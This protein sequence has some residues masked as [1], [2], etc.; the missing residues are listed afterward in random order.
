MFYS[1]I[2]TDLYNL[3]HINK[4]ECQDFLM[5]NFICAAFTKKMYEWEMIV[6]FRKIIK[7]HINILTKFIYQ[8]I[9]NN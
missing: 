5:Q 3:L 9:K 2:Y 1:N 8:Y 7:D 6:K 4:G